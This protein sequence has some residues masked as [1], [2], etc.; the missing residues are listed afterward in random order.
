MGPPS[1]EKGSGP[2]RHPPS[3][4]C[5]G[6]R[7]RICPNRHPSRV[8]TLMLVCLRG[9]FATEFRSK[10]WFH[11]EFLSGFRKLVEREIAQPASLY[12]PQPLPRPPPTLANMRENGV[13]SLSVT[14]AVVRL[15]PLV[16]IDRSRGSSRYVAPTLIRLVL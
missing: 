6:G 15:P 3:P 9:F 2:D 13:R 14:C 5:V 10:L 4:R 12:A 1:I 11:A 16:S 8:A 7:G